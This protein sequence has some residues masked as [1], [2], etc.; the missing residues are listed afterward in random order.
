MQKYALLLTTLI[1]LLYIPLSAQSLISSELIGALT[2]SEIET[3][4]GVD[5]ENGVS[6]YKITYKTLKPWNAVEDTASGLLVLPENYSSTSPIVA[7]QHGTTNGP[8]SCPSNLNAGHSIPIAYGASGFVCT[9][10]DYLGLGE[11]D[12][13]HP[14]VHAESEATA[15]LDMLISSLELMEAEL[16]ATWLGEL[17]VAGY[18]QGGH[19]SMALHRYLQ[20]NF[21]FIWPM[22]KAAHMSGPYDISGVMRD[23]ILRDSVYPYTGFVPY[24]LLGYQEVYGDIVESIPAV[25]KDPFAGFIEDFYSGEINLTELTTQM[26]SA[27]FFLTGAIIPNRIFQDSILDQVTNNSDHPINVALRDN[28]TY[29]WVP[30]APTRLYYCT[31]DDQVPYQNSLVAEAHM[32]SLGADDLKAVDIDPTAN[33]GECAPQAVLESILFFKDMPTGSEPPIA[34]NTSLKIYPNPAIYGVHITL[35]QDGQ[36]I[37][38]VVVFNTNG[39]LVKR[40]DGLNTTRLTMT[41]GDLASGMYTVIIRNGTSVS[42]EK[43]VIL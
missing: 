4:Y 1:S 13:F 31:A 12:I 27:L 16:S 20:D 37:H 15:G 30:T 14:Y 10:A 40:L 19:A 42:V 29:D 23:L 22:K 43:L 26:G 38:E 34:D 17:F 28:D 41:T 35:D 8:E 33:H 39:M 24:A 3:M 32:N 7:Y 2:E 6:L 18:S 25:F 11:S 9:A 36:A 21:S 5:A